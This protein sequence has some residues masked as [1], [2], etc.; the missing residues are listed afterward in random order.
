MKPRA[1]L[2][3]WLVKAHL[4]L[5]LTIGA[6]WAVQGATGAL[7]VYHRDIDRMIGV[8]GTPGP[9]VSLDRVAQAAGGADGLIRI[10][11]RDTAG[12]VLAVD[13]SDKRTVL[14]DAAT[15]R[16]LAVRDTDPTLPG[17]D[18]AAWRWLYQLHEALLL[19][20]AGET[21]IGISGLFLLGAA[22]MGLWL[23]WPRG[24]G[25]RIVFD[26]RRW[27]SPG[28]RL[29]GW[30]RGAGLLA[31]A[32]FV[33]MTLTGAWLIFASDL[34]PVVARW[35]RFEMPAHVAPGTGDIV[36]PQRA[37]EIAQGHFPKARLF[38]VTLPSTKGNAYTV[39]LRQRSELRHLSGTSSVTIDAATGRVIGRYDP[40]TAPIA[41]RLADAAFAVHSGEA[42]GVVGRTMVLL[43]GLS[44]PM[45]YAT[46]LIAWLNRRKRKTRALA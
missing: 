44:L 22:L 3:R 40:L 27:K 45:F 38:R 26:P 7:L 25:W 23:A 37:Y 13:R 34:R 43:L 46:G 33:L 39:R 15:A 20:D 19:H 9:M 29:Y 10:G 8:R 12:T 31:S 5:G 11:V 32:G 1:R 18:G 17:A 4:W 6:V 2:R 21:L 30:H 24:G 41:N 35:V 36:G 42:L 16:V 28:Q 14:I